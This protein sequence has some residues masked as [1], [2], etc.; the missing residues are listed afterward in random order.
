[1]QATIFI[2]RCAAL[3]QRVGHCSHRH[4]TTL[5]LDADADGVRGLAQGERLLQTR[6]LLA[7][8]QHVHLVVA[9]ETTHSKLVSGLRQH[10]GVVRHPL[11]FQQVQNPTARCRQLEK[12]N[13]ISECSSCGA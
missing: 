11:V 8:V 3:Q 6:Q 10:P 12:N 1:M 13:N 5:L 2:G 9:M 7:L 4:C